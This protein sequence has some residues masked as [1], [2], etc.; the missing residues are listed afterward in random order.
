MNTYPDMALAEF[1][2]TSSVN[3]LGDNN[4]AGEVLKD[5]GFPSAS[6]KKRKKLLKMWRRVDERGEG[7]GE[8]GLFGY[9]SQF[10][11]FQVDP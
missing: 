8:R 4:V 5:M 10:G 6:G 1:T 7:Y 11:C 3:K 9:G 2:C